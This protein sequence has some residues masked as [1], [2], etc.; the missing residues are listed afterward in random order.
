MPAGLITPWTIV[1]AH[2]SFVN[3]A[4]DRQ[5]SLGRNSRRAGAPTRGR[6]LLPSG[7]R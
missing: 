5:E 4:R 3:P 1:A 2:K 7:S 6:A